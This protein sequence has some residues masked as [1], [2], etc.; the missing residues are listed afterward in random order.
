MRHNRAIWGLEAGEYGDNHDSL[1]FRSSLKAEVD[2]AST[3]F[4]GVERI[5]SFIDLVK[6]VA[7]CDQAVDVDLSFQ[8][9]INQYVKGLVRTGGSVVATDHRFLV[10]DEIDHVQVRSV[11][12]WGQSYDDRRP[13]FAKR[14]D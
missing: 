13:A 5:K 7:A 2:D 10:S 8:V 3:V 14:I 6:L 9:R 1:K 4:T 12:Y 11:P